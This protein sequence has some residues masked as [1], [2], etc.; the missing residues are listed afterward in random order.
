MVDIHELENGGSVVG[1]GNVVVWRDHHL[2]Q[3]FGTKRG[4]QSAR[5]GSRGQNV[6]LK[7]NLSIKNQLMKEWQA[8]L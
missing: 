2:V 7:K 6:T 3:T 1:D 4:S 8:L 5:N